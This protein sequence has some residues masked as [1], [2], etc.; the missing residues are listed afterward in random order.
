MLYYRSKNEYY[1]YFTGNT[2][3]KNELITKRERNTKYRYLS[4]NC[5]TKVECRK[6][7]TYFSFG[8]R[9]PYTDA[10]VVEL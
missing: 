8:A 5:F 10:K 2:T 4:D 7:D 6:C 9:F 1:D 3:I